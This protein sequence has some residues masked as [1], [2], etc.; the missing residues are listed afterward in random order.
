MTLPN[1]GKFNCFIGG[2]KKGKWIGI[3]LR[4]LRSNPKLAIQTR[5]NLVFNLNSHI[6]LLKHRITDYKYLNY[7]EKLQ[8]KDVISEK[9]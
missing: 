9:E 4:G 1:R 5:K 8:M 3:K 6:K 2:N 7:L